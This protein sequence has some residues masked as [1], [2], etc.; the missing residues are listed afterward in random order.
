MKGMEQARIHL[1]KVMVSRMVFIQ[2]MKKLGIKQ[3][4]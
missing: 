4:H 1:E 2:L 3:K